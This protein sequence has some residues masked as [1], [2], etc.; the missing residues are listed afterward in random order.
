MK[1]KADAG[2]QT[3]LQIS[4]WRSFWYIQEQNYLQN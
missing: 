1:E 4:D 2:F 3:H